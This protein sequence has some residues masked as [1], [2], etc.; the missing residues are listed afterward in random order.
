[1]IRG[2]LYREGDRPKEKFKAMKYFHLGYRLDE[3]VKQE[4]ELAV[5]GEGVVNIE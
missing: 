4:R 1:V 3:I 2:Q 5:K